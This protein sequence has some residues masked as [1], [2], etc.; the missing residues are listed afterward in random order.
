MPES[1]GAPRDRRVILIVASLVVAL[2]A[3][4]VVSA[5]VPGMDGALAS[6]PIVV[7]VLVVGTLVILARTLRR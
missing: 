7:V 4:N 5:L 2:L 6:L 1:G 3:V